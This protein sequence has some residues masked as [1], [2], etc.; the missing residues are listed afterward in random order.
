MHHVVLCNA[1]ED[2]IVAAG[3]RRGMKFFCFIET[4][5]R[6]QFHNHW[7]DHPGRGIFGT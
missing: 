5:T 4:S 7:I 1:Y 6:W 2:R 3:R